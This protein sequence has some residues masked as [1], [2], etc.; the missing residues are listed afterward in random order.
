MPIDQKDLQAAYIDF[1]YGLTLKWILDFDLKNLQY[2]EINRDVKPFYTTRN[3]II[4]KDINDYLFKCYETFIKENFTPDFPFQLENS[5]ENL[6]ETVINNITNKIDEESDD[7]TILSEREYIEDQLIWLMD[8]SISRIE[9]QFCKIYNNES[10]EAKGKEAL[11][12][13]KE[14]IKRKINRIYSEYYAGFD[15][16]EFAAAT[17]K[18]LMAKQQ[19][20]NHVESIA[21][22]LQKV[23]AQNLL[24]FK[25][26]SVEEYGIMRK[27]IKALEQKELDE[28]DQEIKKMNEKIENSILINKNDK[29]TKELTSDEI[30]LVKKGKYEAELRVIKNKLTADIKRFYR[31]AER[32][33]KQFE[34]K[35]HSIFSVENLFSSF[36]ENKTFLKL[37]S[38]SFSAMNN[39]NRERSLKNN[40]KKTDILKKIR[41]LVNKHSDENSGPSRGN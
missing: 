28:L 20:Y 8:E 34:N 41:G 19:K 35:K 13:A 32:K 16:V 15:S 23:A 11:E 17:E 22:V 33:L 40:A 30:D 18:F 39:K 4:K 25:Y 7:K 14:A 38:N 6:K 21:E 37:Y 2:Y 9:E 24:A 36:Y 10:Y 31:A 26:A 12:V 1:R 29:W 3:A 27:S 5:F